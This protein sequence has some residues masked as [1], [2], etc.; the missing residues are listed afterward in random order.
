MINSYNFP[1]RWPLLWRQWPRF[2]LQAIQDGSG[3]R[4]TS[5]DLW[6][7]TETRQHRFHQVHP[8]ESGCDR[9][10]CLSP[11]VL[12][13]HVPTL[14][15]LALSCSR[16][17]LTLYMLFFFSLSFFVFLLG[18]S[19]SYRT[20]HSSFG[21]ISLSFVRQEKP[22]SRRS[23][24][25]LRRSRLFASPRPGTRRVVAKGWR[26]WLVEPGNYPNMAYKTYKTLFQLGKSV[27]MIRNFILMNRVIV[28]ICTNTSG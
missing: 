21:Q 22:T 15:P 9:G 16:F 11:S 12:H 20:S 3:W 25:P 27:E 13:G 14:I 1:E 4:N 26:S 2:R 28:P 5:T 18:H 24:A 10:Y 17:R 6:C 7:L 23:G 19:K 8:K